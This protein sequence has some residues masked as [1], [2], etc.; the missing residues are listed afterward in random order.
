MDNSDIEIEAAPAPDTRA[1]ILKRAREKS[2]ELRRQKAAEKKMVKNLQD[3]NKELEKVSKQ[4]DLIEKNQELKEKVKPKAKPKPTPEPMEEELDEEPE[5]VV[6]PPKKK[7][8]SKKKV[9]V[10]QSSDDSSDD[11]R[12]YMKRVKKRDLFPKPQPPPQPIRKQLTNLDLA[13]LSL[14]GQ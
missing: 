3:E 10:V 13:R 6:V 11:E 2:L 5:I 8:P 12:V 1:E 14:F 9:I 7:K 4:N